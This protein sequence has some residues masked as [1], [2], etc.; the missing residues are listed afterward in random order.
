MTLKNLVSG[1]IFPILTFGTCSRN[2]DD[3]N[4]YWEGGVELIVYAMTLLESEFNILRA[5]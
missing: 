5:K 3:F 4:R 1:K 2:V